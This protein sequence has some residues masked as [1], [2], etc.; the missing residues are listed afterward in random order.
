ME[1][2]EISWAGDDGFA[3]FHGLNWAGLFSANSPKASTVCE[4]GKPALPEGND[5]ELNNQ[6]PLLP[7]S[8]R[9]G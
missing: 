8:G 4:R 7:T 9:R 3:D 6:N 5:T 2:A 1:P